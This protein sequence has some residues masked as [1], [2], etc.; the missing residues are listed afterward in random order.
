MH[1][2]PVCIKGFPSDKAVS[3]LLRALQTCTNVHEHVCTNSH[4]QQLRI[5]LHLHTHAHRPLVK[6]ILQEV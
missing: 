3:L 6:M 4:P 1:I 5:I 2:D